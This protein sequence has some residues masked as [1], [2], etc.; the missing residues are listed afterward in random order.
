MKYTKLTK[1]LTAIIVTTMPFASFAIA[2]GRG[3]V[4]S[5]R[6][7]ETLEDYMEECIQ[8]EELNPKCERLKEEYR[9]DDKTEENIRDRTRSTIESD[10]SNGISGYAGA[11]LGVFFP[12]IDESR[13]FFTGDN[14]DV[15]N[16]IG[17]SIYAG[18]RFNRYLAT[19]IELNGFIGDVDSDLDEDENYSLGAF[20]VN[21][22]FILPLS[23]ERNS[24]S[25]F[26]SPGIGVSQLTSSV[27]DEVDDFDRTSFIE[28]D[29]R[30]T[31]QVK[32][33]VTVPVSTRLAILGQVRYTSQTG[34]NAIDYFG[35]ELGVDFNF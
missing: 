11:T 22:R 23:E 15:D 35:T 4:V 18:I 14:T 6:E 34:N 12:D 31:W 21:P 3:N 29:T 1:Y 16:G 8:S 10:K 13:G 32:G 17:S 24:L 27:E 2:F 9:S 7:I 30:F 20:F 26:L 28:D 5:A 19:D 25:L 33:G